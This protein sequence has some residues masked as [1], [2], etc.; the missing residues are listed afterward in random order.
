MAIE[1]IVHLTF[2]LFVNKNNF[3]FKLFEIY[4]LK[5]SIFELR[6]NEIPKVLFKVD[7]IVIIIAVTIQGINKLI[8][9][10]GKIIS[11]SNYP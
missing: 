7:I 1:I 5:F 9:N 8:L 2:P 6:L 10:P 3:D 11:K 4:T